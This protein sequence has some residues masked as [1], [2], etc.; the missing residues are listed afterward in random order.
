MSWASLGVLDTLCKCDPLCIVATCPSLPHRWIYIFYL[1]N[2]KFSPTMAMEAGGGGVGGG[3]TGQTSCAP[4]STLQFHWLRFVMSALPLSSYV[5]WRVLTDFLP[6]PPCRPGS[7]SVR[8]HDFRI[9][10][11]QTKLRRLCSL[12]CHALSL[13][14]SCPGLPWIE[15][16]HFSTLPAVVCFF[17]EM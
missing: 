15:F 13:P 1:A 6:A 8:L 5:N 10:C 9:C 7:S 11:K 17:F 16:I 2:I 12:P 14:C 3:G 4:A